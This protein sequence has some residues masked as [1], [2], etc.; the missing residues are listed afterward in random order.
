MRHWLEANAS[1]LQARRAGF[2][3]RA[4]GGAALYDALACGAV[5]APVAGYDPLR[6]NTVAS[7]AIKG[8][9]DPKTAL[10]DAVSFQNRSLQPIN[11]LLFLG[12]G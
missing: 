10:D 6:K 12:I 9:G 7:V 5:E 1:T 8:E 11:Q 3:S 2:L 4:D